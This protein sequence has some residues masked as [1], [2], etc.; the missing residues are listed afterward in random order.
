[1]KT[2]E[3]K[4]LSKIH[5]IHAKSTTQD[6]LQ[7]EDTDKKHVKIKHKIKEASKDME[8]GTGTVEFDQDGAISL[9]LESHGSHL[10]TSKNQIPF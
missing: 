2:L 6:F 8:W 7:P 5:V 3:P 9:F 4:K 10:Q 1:M